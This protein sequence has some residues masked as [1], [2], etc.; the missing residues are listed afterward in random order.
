MSIDNCIYIYD[1]SVGIATGYGLYGLGSIPGVERFFCFPQ[2]P[3][4]LWGPLR[5]L[6]KGYRGRFPSDKAAGALSLS[7][8]SIYC[9]SRECLHVIVLN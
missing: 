5:L 9:R 8:I 4:R 1:R 2:G 3:D 6:S 7:I